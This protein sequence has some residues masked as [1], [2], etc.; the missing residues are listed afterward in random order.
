MGSRKP[1]IIAP[2]LQLING[3]VAVHQGNARPKVLVGF[4]SDLLA[5][6][7]IMP[8]HCVYKQAVVIHSQRTGTT[9]LARFSCQMVS[10]QSTWAG[11][12]LK[13]AFDKQD[14]KR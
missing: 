7:W 1:A 14:G 12:K 5:T 10:Y 9:T 13:I 4:D 2:A 8:V 11:G 3:L 6:G